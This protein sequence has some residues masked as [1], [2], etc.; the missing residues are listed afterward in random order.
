MYLS[1]LRGGGLVV[2]LY[3]LVVSLS[4]SFY[5]GSSLGQTQK[6]SLAE[7]YLTLGVAYEEPGLQ[8]NLSDK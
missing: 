4:N 8:V 1:N 6:V 5:V 7:T 2:S 3:G